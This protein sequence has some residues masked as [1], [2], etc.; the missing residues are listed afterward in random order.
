MNNPAKTMGQ[1]FPDPNDNNS[2]GRNGLSRLHF[3]WISVRAADP[4]SAVR[5]GPHE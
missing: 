4:V 2:K 3:A 1:P 5:E